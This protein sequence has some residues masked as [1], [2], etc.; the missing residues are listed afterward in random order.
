MILSEAKT[1]LATLLDIDYA[2]IANNQLFSD[3]ELGY[4]IN[5]AGIMAWDRFPWDFSEA[6]DKADVTD[7]TGKYPYPVHFKAGSIWL[8]LINGEEYERKTFQDY[9]KAL[10]NNSKDKIYCEY[11]RQLYINKAASGIGAVISMYG[12]A[13]YTQLVNVGDLL[14]FSEDSDNEEYSG[15]NAIILIA[16]S[17]ALGSEKKKNPAGAKT[18]L[19]LASAMLNVLWEP[20][21]KGRAGA[22]TKDRPMFN[23]P[24]FFTPGR[25]AGIGTFRNF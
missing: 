6:E 19:D 9:Q 24:D 23:A 3:A 11:G 22:Q 25:G 7:A 21:K 1:A 20:M 18:N 14:P 16:F 4:F 15:N 12:T 2:D 13:K 8:I 10:F 17:Q 5:T